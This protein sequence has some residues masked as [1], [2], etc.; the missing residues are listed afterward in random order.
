MA[1]VVQEQT[2]FMRINFIIVILSLSLSSYAQDHPFYSI[3]DPKIKENL[4]KVDP[5]EYQNA[6]FNG[7]RFKIVGDTDKALEKFSDCIRMNGQEAAPMYESAS[8]YFNMGQVDQ[9]F[10]FIENACKLEPKN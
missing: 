6:F 4:N 3:N 1:L 2:N 8:L 5:K 7:L 9:A 10:F